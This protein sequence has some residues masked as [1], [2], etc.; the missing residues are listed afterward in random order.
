MLFCFSG[1]LHW[2]IIKLG[3][4]CI[5]AVLFAYI[6]GKIAERKVSKQALRNLMLLV[7]FTAGFIAIVQIK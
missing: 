3:F 1:K 2:S 5:P 7:S 4:F 6:C